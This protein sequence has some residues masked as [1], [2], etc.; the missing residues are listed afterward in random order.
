MKS[1]S[2]LAA[3]TFASALTPPPEFSKRDSA[4]D[5]WK[6]TADMPR[7]GLLTLYA[8]FACNPLYTDRPTGDRRAIGGE[9]ELM[10][11]KAQGCPT[12]ALQLKPPMSADEPRPKEA[13]L[14]MLAPIGWLVTGSKPLTAE[15]SAIAASIEPA[16]Q[17]VSVSAIA[18]CAAPW[19]KW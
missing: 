6:F 16:P 7:I 3:V 1:W 15:Q 8:H 10:P 18:C 4:Y 2:P 13:K 12:A 5:T 9:S 19:L 14:P 17:A 11:P